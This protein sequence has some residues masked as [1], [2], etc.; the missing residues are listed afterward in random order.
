M[1]VK[2][3]KRASISSS[4]KNGDQPRTSTAISYNSGSSGE[5]SSDE[6]SGDDLI[7]QQ[8][9][10][11]GANNL[12]CAYWDVQKLIKYT[13]VTFFHHVSHKNAQIHLA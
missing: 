10:N 7:C 4:H 1:S 9:K 5:D 12:D 6:D 3:A 13:R 8:L 11:K 2:S